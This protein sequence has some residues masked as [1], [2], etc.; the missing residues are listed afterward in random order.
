MLV[1]QM[2]L[3][4]TA[5]HNNVALGQELEWKKVQLDKARSAW[6]RVSVWY[7]LLQGNARGLTKDNIVNTSFRCDS[8]QSQI[9]KHPIVA[10]F[11]LSF[12]GLPTS[13]K[14]NMLS[15]STKRKYRAIVIPEWK[16][17]HQLY[18]RVPSNLLRT[19]TQLGD[20]CPL[21]GQTPQFHC[22]HNWVSVTNKPCA[23]PKTREGFT[24][25]FP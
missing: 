6:Q 15:V 8:L 2:N 16:W 25:S 23:H 9:L 4:L 5:S 19:P 12:P 20:H 1:Q 22:F 13:T 10:N 11:S 14:I 17:K 18:T 7:Q 24:S 21:T 3:V